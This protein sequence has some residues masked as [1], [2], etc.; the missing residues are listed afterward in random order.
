MKTTRWEGSP[1][2]AP[3]MSVAARAVLEDL[4]GSAVDPLDVA[5]LALELRAHLP[6]FLDAC[7]VPR[8]APELGGGSLAR[9]IDDL[10]TGPQTISVSEPYASV[11][12]TL[13]SI[14]ANFNAPNP[15]NEQWRW[16][17][18]RNAMFARPFDTGDAWSNLYWFTDFYRRIDETVAPPAPPIRDGMLAWDAAAAD[19]L[20]R[21]GGDACKRNAATLRER[22]RARWAAFCEPAV[23]NLPGIVDKEPLVVAAERLRELAKLW[24]DDSST[25]DGGTFEIFKLLAV[26]LWGDEVGPKLARQRV[27]ASVLFGV[28]R[29]LARATHAEIREHDHR[30]Q[31]HRDGAGVIAETAVF[32]PDA[33]R[34]L[35]Q[36]GEALTGY[37][38]QVTWRGIL[39]MA[40]ENYYAGKKPGLVDIFLPGGLTELAERLGVSTGRA[41]ITA[42][43]QTLKAGQH[44]DFTSRGTGHTGGLWT[45]T[46]R[47]SAP[48]RAQEVTILPA[49]DL[50]PL[51][52]L[53]QRAGHQK[54]IP[55][56]PMPP[57]AGLRANDWAAVGALQLL[58]LEA[59]TDRRL[60]LV[61]HGGA[62]ISDR[63]IAAMANESHLPRDVLPRVL[64]AWTDGDDATPPMLEVVDRNAGT[65]KEPGARYHLTAG[66]PY[67]QGRDF[68]TRGGELAR[69]AQIG[70]RAAARKRPTGNVGKR[71][72]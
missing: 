36:A 55:L 34:A 59:L 32:Q 27:G 48:N 23:P 49:T 39:L 2:P 71:Q 29:S 25:R 8:Y 26:S 51:A 67:G 1:D 61:T 47:P 58:F 28:H 65:A 69:K 63:T 3:F 9:I 41:T 13:E 57:F 20:E 10:S 33:L 21:L 35:K 30:L 46:E 17:V 45:W 66:G 16:A 18:D 72:R 5:K 62:L 44:F 50:Q 54:L 37:Y 6:A 56:V 15:N 52:H 64:R 12:I 43:R 24:L 19:Y 7:G 14:L 4:E 38:G 53:N 68:L 60:E 22:A 40:W 70:A 31:L 11:S 42:L